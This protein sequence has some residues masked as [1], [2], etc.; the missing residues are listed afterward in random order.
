MSFSFLPFIP[1][2]CFLLPVYTAVFD[3]KWR[4]YS[5]NPGL[6]PHYIAEGAVVTDT[7]ITEGCE[8]YGKVNHS[9][10]FAGVVIEEGADVE[11]S[12]V[13]PGSV[14]KRGSIVRRSIIAEN[15]TVG[16]GSIVGEKEGNI[17]VVG[18]GV[19][20]PAGVSVS[21]GQQVDESYTF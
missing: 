17:A 14:I 16:A 21:A 5:K 13:M 9:I 3:K 6:P 19:V 20:L 4:I 15:A 1:W 7:L 18:Q 2:F 12:V 11:Y 8:V 10:L